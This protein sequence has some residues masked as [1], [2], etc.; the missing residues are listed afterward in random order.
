[1][2]L[3]SAWSLDSSLT[4]VMVS[5][6]TAVHGPSPATKVIFCAAL[7][8][9]AHARHRVVEPVLDLRPR[10]IRTA[11]LSFSR[12]APQAVIQIVRRAS[13]MFHRP[14]ATSRLILA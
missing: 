4:I 8:P 7:V 6:L 14:D 12:I 11:V 10:H 9:P 1:M 5:A 2:A 3:R 13:D